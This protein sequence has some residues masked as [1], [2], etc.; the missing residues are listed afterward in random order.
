MKV[1]KIK[2]DKDIDH[3][4][5]Y[6]DKG[7][8]LNECGITAKIIPTPGHTGDHL[9]IHLLEENVVF[10]GDCLLGEGRFGKNS[11]CLWIRLQVKMSSLYSTLLIIC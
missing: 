8:T 1:Y 2:H 9:I 7:L 11:I 3:K 4:F 5:D 6:I 10:S